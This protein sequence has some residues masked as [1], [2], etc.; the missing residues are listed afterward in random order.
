MGHHVNPPSF[1][2]FN[3]ITK[4]FSIVVLIKLTK[5][6]EAGG[7]WLFNGGTWESYGGML[8]GT[9]D[10]SAY[11]HMPIRFEVYDLLD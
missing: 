5:T 9:R 11:I 10:G 6:L 4:K 2:M 1:V 7:T 8:K 3:N